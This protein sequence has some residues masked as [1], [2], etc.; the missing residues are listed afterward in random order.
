ALDR[1]TSLDSKQASPVKLSRLR[2]RLRIDS[3]VKEVKTLPG[4]IWQRWLRVLVQHVAQVIV[5][6]FSLRPGGFEPEQYKREMT[7]N[8]D[9]R[10]VSGM[11]RMIIDCTM[12]QADE[13]ESSL[14]KMHANGLIHFGTHRSDQAIMTCVTPNVDNHEHV[15]FIDGGDG[16]LYRA[17]GKLKSQIAADAS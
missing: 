8:A 5:F 13:I 12:Q 11:L 10:K 6:R 17:A 2:A 3:M 4:P 15:H 1:I 16:G 14:V 9:F 7:V